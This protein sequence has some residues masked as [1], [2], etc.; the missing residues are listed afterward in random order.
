MKQKL[1]IHNYFWNNFFLWVLLVFSKW[2][3]K[4]VVLLLDNNLCDKNNFKGVIKLFILYFREIIHKWLFQVKELS[5]QSKFYNMKLSDAA[6]QGLS[7]KQGSSWF[8]FEFFGETFI[9][10]CNE[11]QNGSEMNK[12]LPGPWNLFLII[13]VAL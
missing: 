8:S 10:R 4:N 11:W 12:D 1:G 2:S 6:S 9:I 13:L 5:E 7:S 3:F